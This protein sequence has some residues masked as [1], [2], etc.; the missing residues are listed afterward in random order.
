MQ[1]NKKIER[2]PT[3]HDLVD[4]LTEYLDLTDEEKFR[5]TAKI[6]RYTHDDKANFAHRMWLY[7]D[8]P[9][10]EEGDSFISDTLKMKFES[11]TAL[12]L[13]PDEQLVTWDVG[14]HKFRQP[15][16]PCTECHRVLEGV[17]YLS[18]YKEGKT[19]HNC[20]PCAEANGNWEEHEAKSKYETI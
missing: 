1:N 6:K 16:P 10:K 3:L 5:V 15:K 20:R 9:E 2:F 17:D 14:T 19:I 13:L 11:H 8:G 18:L 7:S 4:N 12:S